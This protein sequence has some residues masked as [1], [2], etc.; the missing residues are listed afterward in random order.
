MDARSRKREEVRR[1]NRGL[2]LRLVATGHCHSRPEIA[3]CTGLSRMSVTSIVSE[4]LEAGYLTE[5]HEQIPQKERGRN[6][7]SL[8]ISHRAPKL[9]GVLISRN[10][11]EGICCDLSLHVL[12]R[13]ASILGPSTT[14]ESLI[15][16][17]FEILDDILVPGCS[18]AAIGVSSVGPVSS[19]SGMILKPFYFFNI[20]DVPIVRLLQNR[21]HI[22]VFL[23]HDNQNAVLAE[24]MYGK[25]RDT[26][27]LLFLG[28]GDGIGSG[29][30]SCGKRYENTRG[31]PPEIGHVSIDMNGRLCPCGNRGCLE[32][33][34]RSE[35]VLNEL[36]STT[37]LPLSYRQFAEL[38]DHPEV[39]RVFHAVMKRLAA[40]TINVLN[41]VHCQTVILGNDA[42]FW[43]E[44]Y[45][46]ELEQYVNRYQFIRERNEIRIVK[47]SFG[48]D[49]AL[50][51]AAANA[52][53]IIFRGNILFDKAHDEND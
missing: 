51:G 13:R 42:S 18:V 40:G 49:D 39:D 30:I 35:T 47:A 53:E 9:A 4:M 17:I 6:A 20:H 29:I 24:Y 32:T 3:E 50:L 7:V 23:D 25:W 43:K 16:K 38:Q 1:E 33:Y 48:R 41:I 12:A 27:D 46:R 22:P 31:L 11:I 14:R 8:S 15:R 37:G 10:R 5:N 34:I 26:E 2:I 28:V 21:Y 52:A 45:V 44:Q 19:T 36:R